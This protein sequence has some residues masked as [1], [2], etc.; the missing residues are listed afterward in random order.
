MSSKGPSEQDLGASGKGPSEQDL[1]A[2][3]KGPSEQDLRASG[4]GP[5]EQDLRASGKGPREQDLRASGKGPR[6]QD[7]RAS[8]KRPREQDL[9]AM[10]ACRSLKLLKHLRKTAVPWDRRVVLM[11]SASN[12][13]DV[14]E[15]AL[16]NGCPRPSVEQALRVAIMTKSD[17]AAR[18]IE[19]NAR[20]FDDH[21]TA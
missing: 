13:V 4:K 14:L 18:W 17:D 11:A 3:G 2:S 21:H 20:V 1:R 10:A 9:C 16:R 8:G 5:R 12:H 7:L 6:E 19:C 15:W